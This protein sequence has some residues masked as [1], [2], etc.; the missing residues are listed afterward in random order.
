MTIQNITM[1]QL[2]ESVT[3][4]TIERWLIKPGDQVKKYDAL[5]E[6]QTDK[7]TAE[8]PSSFTG[9]ISE[10]IA[11]EGDTIEVGKI[12]CTIEI[13]D[14]VVNPSTVT[15]HSKESS[16][17]DQNTNTS[18]GKSMKTRYSPAVVRLA[19]EHQ[20]DLTQVEGS[21][22]SGRITRKDIKRLLKRVIFLKRQN[23]RWNNQT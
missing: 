12:V 9:T 5:A 15:T 14:A 20:I 21:G 18:N 19:S 17:E 22:A 4:G 6:V 23:K 7:V 16:N 1:P 8:L 2:G 11:H 3:E 10:L 13:E